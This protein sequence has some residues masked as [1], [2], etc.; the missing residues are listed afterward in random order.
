ML[1]LWAALGF[2]LL[3]STDAATGGAG[4]RLLVVLTF[5]LLA[6]VGLLIATWQPANA[7]GWLILAGVLVSTFDLLAN[8]FVPYALSRAPAAAQAFRRLRT[9]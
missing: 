2:P 7:I 8:S 1:V 9:F 6:V 5:A 4:F 3:L